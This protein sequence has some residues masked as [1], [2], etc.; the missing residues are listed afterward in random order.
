[1]SLFAFTHDDNDVLHHPSQWGEM[2][3]PSPTMGEDEQIIPHLGADI[4]TVFIIPY[5]IIS[6]YIAIIIIIIIIMIILSLLASLLLSS[7]SLLLLLLYY[8]YCIVVILSGYYQM[9]QPSLTVG[10]DEPNILQSG[11]DKLTIPHT[12]GR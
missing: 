3:H 9:N 2:N 6:Y 7:L 11:E 4:I 8:Y 12:G 1:M 10:E 5:S